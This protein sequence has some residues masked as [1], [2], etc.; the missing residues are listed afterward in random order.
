MEENKPHY[1]KARL[2]SEKGEPHIPIEIEVEHD[3]YVPMK[4]EKVTWFKATLV[5]MKPPKP[6]KIS[7]D[8]IVGLEGLIDADL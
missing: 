2:Y 6:S 7:D 5:N 4:P 3:I 1:I 8:E